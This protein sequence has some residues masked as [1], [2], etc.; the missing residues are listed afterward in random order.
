MI[1]K[2]KKRIKPSLM[3]TELSYRRQACSPNI[4]DVQAPKGRQSN[5]C[6]FLCRPFGA[7]VVGPLFT[8]GF[9]CSLTLSLAGRAEI[10]IILLQVL[11]FKG[12]HLVAIHIQEV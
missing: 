5:I 7:Y 10:Q 11:F 8:T 1:L 6:Y 4:P 9:A 2:N 3:A 12:H